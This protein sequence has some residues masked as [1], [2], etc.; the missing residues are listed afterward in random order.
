[1]DPSPE[2]RA[3]LKRVEANLK[4]VLVLKE[5]FWIKKTGM[6]W[7]MQGDRNLKFFHSYV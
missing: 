7:F 5:E 1:M 2:K 6:R 3:D 4:R